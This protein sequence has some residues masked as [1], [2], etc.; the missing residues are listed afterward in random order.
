MTSSPST[1]EAD[2]AERLGNAVIVGLVVSGMMGVFL[3]YAGVSADIE[4]FTFVGCALCGLPILVWALTP[5]IA[6]AAR[7]RSRG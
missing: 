6:E 1:P 2:R 7:R 3:F 4:A 5:W